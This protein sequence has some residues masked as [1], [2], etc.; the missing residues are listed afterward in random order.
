[1]NSSREI[2]YGALFAK[3][4]AAVGPL[5]FNTMSRRSRLWTEVPVEE[6][7][8]M[9]MRQVHEKTIVAGREIPTK[10]ELLV[11]VP[12]YVFA[13]PGRDDSAAPLMNAAI[14]NIEKLFPIGGP[15]KQD[16][17]GLVVEARIFG[18]IMIGEDNLTGQGIAVIPIRVVAV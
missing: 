9:F 3:L 2:I 11:D 18:D 10:W 13:G 15:V 14:D 17:N 16:L 4:Q 12:I 1:M 6:Q 8:A 7:P 5:G